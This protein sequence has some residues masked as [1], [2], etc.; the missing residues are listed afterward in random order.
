[1][2]AG[3]LVCVNVIGL[4]CGWNNMEMMEEPDTVNYKIQNHWYK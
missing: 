2:S 4:Y 1:M 3:G